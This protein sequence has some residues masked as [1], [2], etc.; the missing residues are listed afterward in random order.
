MKND[1][2]DLMQASRPASKHPKMP[3]ENRAKIFAPFDAL[4]GFNLAVMAKQKERQLEVRAEL[5]EDAQCE[6]QRVLSAVAI[7]DEVR[8]R[9]FQPEQTIGDLQLGAYRSLSGRVERIDTLAR[10]LT[11]SGEFIPIDEIVSAEKCGF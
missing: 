11:V 10:I 1:Y 7:G 4:R 9:Y 5:S 8:L 3:L 6:L 2:T